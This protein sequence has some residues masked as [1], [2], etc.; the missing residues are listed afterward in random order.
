MPQGSVLGP[1]LFLIFIN[2]ITENTNCNIRLFADDT[3]LFVDFDNAPDGA[4]LINNYLQTIYAWANKWLVSFCPSKTESMLVS[5]M[6]GR[7]HPTPVYFGGSPFQE[8][9]SHQHLGITLTRNVWNIHVENIVNKA[10]KRVDIMA[11][12]KYRLDRSSLETIYKSFIRPILEYGDIMLSNMT[13]EQATFI[14]HLDKRAGIII[15]GA[16][17]GTS[18]ATILTSLCGSLW[19]K[20]ENNTGFVPFIR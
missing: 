11:Y 16:T 4:E 2:D 14:Q 6:N 19:P 3:T 5:L 18:S 1:L 20:E 9:D 15:S 13:D 8:V 10:G 17:R 12:L 7:V